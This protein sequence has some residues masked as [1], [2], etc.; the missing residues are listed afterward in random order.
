MVKQ[1]I[2][3]LGSIVMAFLFV[4]QPVLA[5]GERLSDLAEDIGDKA[6]DIG[7][8]VGGTVSDTA[9]EVGH[10]MGVGLTAREIDQGADRALKNL[11]QTIGVMCITFRILENR[12]L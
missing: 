3:M 11:Y 4:N 6:V 8:K 7:G 10:K 2:T 5:L 1:F 9:Q 12:M